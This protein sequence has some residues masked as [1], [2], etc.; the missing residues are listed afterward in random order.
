MTNSPEEPPRPSN[1]DGAGYVDRRSEERTATVLR[2][3]LLQSED[4]KTFC[5]VRN[6]SGSGLKARVFAP[7]KDGIQIAIQMSDELVFDGQVIWHD[8]EAIGME[9]DK[10]IN[11][12]S[13]LT[14]LRTQ[15]SDESSNRPPRLEVVSHARFII[16]GQS[17]ALEVIDISSRGIKARS[18]KSTPPIGDEGTLAIDGLAPR[19]AIP[20]WSRDGSVGFQLLEPIGFTELGQW[21]MEQYKGRRGS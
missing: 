5:L 1:D 8:S 15:D 18:L 7:V 21:I 10:P 6:I 19:K 11:L 20:R 14:A 3:A 9:F 2:P 4:F 17:H 12:D 13:T 16:H